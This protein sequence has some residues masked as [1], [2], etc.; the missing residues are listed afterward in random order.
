LSWIN[1]WNIRGRFLVFRGSWAPLRPTFWLENLPSL[2]TEFYKKLRLLFH[3]F[4]AST[5]WSQ[6]WGKKLGIENCAQLPINKKTSPGGLVTVWFNYCTFHTLIFLS[7]FHPLIGCS[8]YFLWKKLEGSFALNHFWSGQKSCMINQE[9]NL[10]V[11][12]CG[13]LSLVIKHKKQ[14]KTI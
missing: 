8:L 5:I 2:S 3:D 6:K 11:S 14:Q 4:C 13:T 7:I 12:I 1:S 10:F 9:K